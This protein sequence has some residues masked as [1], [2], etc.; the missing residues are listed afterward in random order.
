MVDFDDFLSRLDCSCI[1]KQNGQS[2]S[3]PGLWCCSRVCCVFRTVLIVQTHRPCGSKWDVGAN[4]LDVSFLLSPQQKESSWKIS[5]LG[6][7]KWKILIIL[8]VQVMD[9]HY[10]YFISKKQVGKRGERLYEGQIWESFSNTRTDK[11]I[12][13]SLQFK[14]IKAFCIMVSF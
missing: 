5:F 11:W 12:S 13:L 10:Y 4:P 2:H 1:S 6:K 8:S 14:C 3:V 9:C 7:E